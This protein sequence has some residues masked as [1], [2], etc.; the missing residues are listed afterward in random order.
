MKAVCSF[1]NDKDFALEI[2][3]ER[4]FDVELN[5]FSSSIPNDPFKQEF[6][7]ILMTLAFPL[8]HVLQFFHVF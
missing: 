3:V 5:Y 7:K 1:P 6:R 8:S 4:Y 2:L